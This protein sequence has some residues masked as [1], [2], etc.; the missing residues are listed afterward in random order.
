MSITN[1]KINAFGYILTK[2]IIYQKEI[3]SSIYSESDFCNK[4]SNKRLMKLL[5][6]L[7]LESVSINEQDCGL[8]NTFDRMI[9]YPNGPVEQDVYD[10]LH[11]VPF[12]VYQNGRFVK[13]PSTKECIDYYK[14]EL[15][16]IK[17]KECID[18]AFNKLKNTLSIKE[19]LD[20]DA[21][22]E[23]IHKLYLWTEVYLFRPYN[24][25]L[26]PVTDYEMIRKELDCYKRK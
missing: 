19:F 24:D 18:D 17:T 4:F 23:K 16:D 1:K 25:R 7:C 20:R 3:E 2:F 5:Y 12:A 8:F 10:G 6:L 15:F 14:T 26:M 21:L 13:F 9:A 11:L 22:I